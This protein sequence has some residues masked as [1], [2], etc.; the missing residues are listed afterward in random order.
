M[1]ND[2]FNGLNDYVD[3]LDNLA[4]TLYDDKVNVNQITDDLVSTHVT[5]QDL[6]KIKQTMS[7]LIANV[8]D[9]NHYLINYQEEGSGEGGGSSTAGSITTEL[10]QYLSNEYIRKNQLVVNDAIVNDSV[11][12]LDEVY[13]RTKNIFIDG[14]KISPNS[15][16]NL[17]SF[18]QL[19]LSINGLTGSFSGFFQDVIDTVCA[20]I[21]GYPTDVTQSNIH[22]GDIYDYGGTRII[23][24]STYTT[25]TTYNYIDLTHPITLVVNKIEDRHNESI[26][27]TN[28]RVDQCWTLLHDQTDAVRRHHYTNEMNEFGY[29]IRL[30]GSGYK[31][32]NNANI[33]DPA[34]KEYKYVR[35][36]S[37]NL[38]GDLS[39]ITKFYDETIE[40]K[41]VGKDFPFSA[42]ISVSNLNSFTT[43]PNRKFRIIRE[44]NDSYDYFQHSQGVCTTAT[45]N[46][47]GMEDYI[48]QGFARGWMECG[49]MQRVYMEKKS[50]GFIYC[51]PSCITFPIPF[52]V[53]QGLDI[54]VTQKR[55]ICQPF[56]Y[57]VPI[58]VINEDTYFFD[59]GGGGQGIPDGTT[60]FM[61]IKWKAEGIYLVNKLLQQWYIQKNYDKIHDL[62]WING[63]TANTHYEITGNTPF[64]RYLATEEQLQDNTFRTMIIW[65]WGDIKAIYDAVLPNYSGKNDTANPLSYHLTHG[66]QNVPIPNT[67]ITLANYQFRDRIGMM[68]AAVSF[69][70]STHLS[71]L[72]GKLADYSNASTPTQDIIDYLSSIIP[73]TAWNKNSIR[74]YLDWEVNTNV[75]AYRQSNE[76]IKF[77]AG[78]LWQSK[79]E[80]N[81]YTNPYYYAYYEGQYPGANGTTDDDRY[82]L[83]ST[84]T[85]QITNWTVRTDTSSTGGT[86]GPTTETTTIGITFEPSPSTMTAAKDLS[87]CLNDPAAKTVPVGYLHLYDQETW[88]ASGNVNWTIAR[89]PQDTNGYYKFSNLKA[90]IFAHLDFSY[91]QAVAYADFSNAQLNMSNGT[92][93]NIRIVRSTLNGSGG[94]DFPPLAEYTALP[95]ITTLYFNPSIVGEQYLYIDSAKTQEMRDYVHNE[96]MGWGKRN[97]SYTQFKITISNSSITL[98]L[99]GYCQYFHD[100]SP[101]DAEIWHTPVNNT[102]VSFIRS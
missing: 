78:E 41:I 16:Y 102:S 57:I 30:L 36:F 49:G 62:Y 13:L 81:D 85:G 98:R 88:I 23:P 8:N 25:N 12:D 32:F 69:L 91:A 6:N 22:I 52:E 60:G 9:I 83:R 50:D 5:A 15:Q 68:S 48:Y 66:L 40:N 75:N 46:Y 55:D 92:I 39:S 79:A 72:S 34:F 70:N 77:T 64:D 45:I 80:Y 35:V 11:E 19:S 53:G 74:N 65:L 4:S 76:K 95:T 38:P 51:T 61:Y 58:S 87:F 24:I 26:N 47:Q 21:R 59:I 100:N 84:V 31:I 43:L 33:I 17:V 63:A 54:Q 2:Y 27:Y 37:D 67:N 1:N 89:R 20:W 29:G 3:D 42:T 73:N 7:T 94:W 82:R 99:I 97:N 93:T 101:P 56:P 14:Y 44:K 28:Y 90:W 10:N 86:T 18:N 96:V 71:K